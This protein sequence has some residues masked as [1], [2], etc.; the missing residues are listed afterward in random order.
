ML[1]VSGLR[2]AYPDGSRELVVLDDVSF[3]LAAGDFVGL[4]GKR[5]S[6]KSTLLRILAGFDAPDRGS[7]RLDGRELTSMSSDRRALFSRDRVAMASSFFG[8]PDRNR[9]VRE[10]IGMAQR[11]DGRATGRHAALRVREVLHEVGAQDCYEAPLRRLSLGERIRVELARALV[12]RPRLLLIDDPP[13]LHSPS[14][15]EDLYELLHSLGKD[16]ERTVLLASSEFDLAQ[17]APR[18]LRLGGGDLRVM[19][20]EATIV[21]FPVP[22]TGTEQA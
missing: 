6:G 19:D 2:K 22:K 12:R 20:R 18:L 4:Y 8:G 1:E 5:R 21:R 9:L 17:R 7:V 16:A 13:P 11:V 14:E 10:H 3:A 15:G